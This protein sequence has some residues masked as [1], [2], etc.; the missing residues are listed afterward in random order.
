MEYARHSD[1]CSLIAEDKI[2]RDDKLARTFFR[3][4]I[5]GLE[6]LH[7][8]KV[9]HLDLKLDNLFLTEDF[10]LKIGDFDISKHENEAEYLS[11]GTRNYR[12][13]EIID[14]TC[15][16]AY[17]ADIFSVGVIFFLFVTRAFPYSE[18]K[19]VRSHDLFDILIK[20]KDTYWSTIEKIK[21]VSQSLLTDDFRDLFMNM[22]DADPAKRFELSQIKSSKWYKGEI[23][24]VNEV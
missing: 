21:M 22:V 1:F 20:R 15:Q 3:Q 2:P 10:T 24:D 5:E 11:K 4:M 17:K 8:N 7:A 6:Y 9:A 23:Y 12:P 19:L 18:T 16:D 13:P 14:E